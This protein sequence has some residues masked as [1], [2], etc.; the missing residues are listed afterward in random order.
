MSPDYPLRTTAASDIEKLTFPKLDA[1]TVP[2]CWG[3]H[4]W[5][6][7]KR[8]KKSYWACITCG[9]VGGE[10]SGPKPPERQ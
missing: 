7:R 6:I 5:N 3:G 4:K 8:K 9:V 1:L 2:K 10:T